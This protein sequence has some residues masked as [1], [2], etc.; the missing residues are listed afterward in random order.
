LNPTLNDKNRII[1]ADGKAR[2]LIELTEADVVIC[3]HT[4]GIIGSFEET[5]AAHN[6]QMIVKAASTHRL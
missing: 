1:G 3:S 5:D 6:G 4:V 2:K